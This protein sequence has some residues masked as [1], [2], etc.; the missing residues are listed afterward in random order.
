MDD[1]QKYRDLFFE[2][3][4]EYLQSL[5]ENLLILEKDTES[6]GIIDEIFRSAHTLKG[7]AATM[8]FRLDLAKAAPIAAAS[9]WMRA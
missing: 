4:D 9:S 3:T 6:P 7:M 1:T 2:E 5:N 8:T